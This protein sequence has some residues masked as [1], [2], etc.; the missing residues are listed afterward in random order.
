MFNIGDLDEM[1]SEVGGKLGGSGG[2]EV[3]GSK[4]FKKGEIYC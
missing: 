4:C 1:I 2:I 3:I